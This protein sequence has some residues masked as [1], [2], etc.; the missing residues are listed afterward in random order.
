MALVFPSGPDVGDRFPLDP[1]LPGVTQWEWDGS[2]WNVVPTSVQLG[3]TPNQDAFNGYLWPNNSP[4]N[5]SYLESTSAGVLS[6]T[7]YTPP[8]GGKFVK[9]NNSLG[10]NAYVWPNADGAAGQ[11]L[12]TDG[13]GNLSWEVTASTSFVL[14]DNISGDFDGVTVT[15]PLTVGGLPFTPVPVT[16][17][18]VFLGGIPQIPG[19]SNAYTVMGNMIIFTQAPAIGT[20]FYAISSEIV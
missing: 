1:G 5:P 17:I 11:Q 4:T 14:L 13:A 9:L 6:W 19:S 18:I 8:V 10:Y 16:N 20:T 2:V 3:P 7:D 15:F 12:T